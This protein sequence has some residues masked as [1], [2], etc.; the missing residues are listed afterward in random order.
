MLT[1]SAAGPAQRGGKL[2][3]RPSVLPSR[4]SWLEIRND[5][6]SPALAAASSHRRLALAANRTGRRLLSLR[7]VEPP[8]LLDGRVDEE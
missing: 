6:I 4:G 3:A 5:A 1:A 7:V 2:V 8:S